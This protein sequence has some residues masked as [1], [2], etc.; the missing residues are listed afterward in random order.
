MATECS[1]CTASACN[2]THSCELWCR[3]LE[4]CF[5][6]ALRVDLDHLVGCSGLIALLFYSLYCELS[7]SVNIMCSIL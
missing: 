1:I 2:F 6:L 3:H 4:N 5:I 7:F